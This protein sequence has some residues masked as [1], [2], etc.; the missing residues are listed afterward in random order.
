[1]AT[2]DRFALLL[3]N[4]AYFS[5]ARATLIQA[6]RSVTLL[7]WIFDPR[8]DLVH[9]SVADGWPTRVGELLN[10]LVRDR[11]DLQIRLLVWDAPAALRASR[12]GFPQRA[13]A[14]LDP[15]I[16]LRFA[17]ARPTGA[18]HHQKL[19]IVDE[20]VAFCGGADLMSNRW[21][22]ADHR[23]ADPRRRRPSGKVHPARHDVTAVVDGPAALAL[24]ELAAESWGATGGRD[25]PRPSKP[26]H[27]PWPRAVEPQARRLQVAIARTRPRVGARAAARECEALHL[28]AIASAKRSLYLETQYF[29]SSRIGRAIEARLREREGPEVVV[30]CSPRSPSAFDRIVMDPA[31]DALV[32]RLNRAGPNGRFRAYAPHTRSGAEILVHSKLAIA[33][34]RLLHLGSSN[35]NNRSMAVDTE[36][37]LAIEAPA[38]GGEALVETI[39]AARRD[40]VA[41]F[42]DVPG[43]AL[44][45]LDPGGGGLVAAIDALD[46]PTERRLRPLKPDP[47]RGLRGLAAW[48]H[49]GDPETPAD[50]WRPWRR[51][52]GPA[53][54]PWATAALLCGLAAAAGLAAVERY[55]VRAHFFSRR[56]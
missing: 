43:E 50:M 19:L 48:S 56:S 13:R 42:L 27:R 9:E 46:S 26:D 15:R 5:A 25:A 44:Q 17:R 22:T 8:T 18:A 36:C 47:P 35:L 52:K 31:R 14:W 51:R 21:D 54:F 39:R 45:R 38:A 32:A 34:D 4:A 2:A 28:A 3:D 37:D 40:L 41:H 29:A 20:A 16:R 11:P 49:L 24:S 33:D 23:D 10:R 7:G 1:M 6:E 53:P 30:V 55:G 12:G